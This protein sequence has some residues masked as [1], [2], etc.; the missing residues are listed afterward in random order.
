M[1]KPAPVREWAPVGPGRRVW[2]SWLVPLAG[3]TIRWPRLVVARLD[4][5]HLSGGL[6]RPLRVTVAVRDHGPDGETSPQERPTVVL[7]DEDAH[8]YALHDLGELTGDNVPRHQGEL[9]PG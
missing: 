6:L 1:V 9:G 4:F 8:R 5:G 2:R 3:P 7:F